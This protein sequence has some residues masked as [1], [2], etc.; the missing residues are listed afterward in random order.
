MK[1]L[2]TMLPVWKLTLALSL[3]VLFVL[4]GVP[5]GCGKSEEPQPVKIEQPAAP[6]VKLSETSAPVAR[7]IGA[8]FD[9]FVP[10]NVYVYV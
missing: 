6:G 2:K 9:S 1:N 3:G 4:A 5:L 8:N 10:E 7:E